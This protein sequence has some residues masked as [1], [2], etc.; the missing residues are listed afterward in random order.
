MENK[1]LHLV[2][3]PSYTE[4]PDI[5]YGGYPSSGL[6]G[7]ITNTRDINGEMLSVGDLV[8]VTDVDGSWFTSLIIEY[9]LTTNLTYF[10]VAG[11]VS[12]KLEDLS[13]KRKVEKVLSYRVMNQEYRRYINYI[14]LSEK[15]LDS[16]WDFINGSWSR[17]HPDVSDR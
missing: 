13:N 6:I 3:F 15:Y 8:K 9:T 4:M 11:M 7:T 12:K 17:I 2:W 5:N 14:S 16:S 1:K 10:T